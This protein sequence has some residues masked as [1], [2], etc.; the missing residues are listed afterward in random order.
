V[1]P[2]ERNPRFTGTETTAVTTERVEMPFERFKA[3]VCCRRVAAPVARQPAIPDDVV[4][5]VSVAVDEGAPFV[6]GRVLYVVGGP[7]A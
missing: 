7:K 2:H 6:S 4:V 3:A 1:R 5:A